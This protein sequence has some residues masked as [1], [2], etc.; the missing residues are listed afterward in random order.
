MATTFEEELYVDK[1]G[2]PHWDGENMA[3]LREYKKRV[4]IEFNT[5]S[6]TTDAGKEKRANLGL[7]LTRGLSGKAWKMVEPLLEDM[8]PLTQTG[9]HELI[10]L[11]LEK[12]DKVAIVRKQQKFDDF[13]K[14][15]RRKRGMEIKEYVQ[16]FHRRYEELK[17]L[18]KGTR[19]SDDLYAY[20][21]L[22]GALLTDDQ[23]R[24]IIMCANNQYE[25]V[26]FEKTLETNYHDLHL[27]EQR[28]SRFEK[29]QAPGAGKSAGKSGKKG[30][31]KKGGRGPGKAY[32]TDYDPDGAHE[33]YEYEEDEEECDVCDPDDAYEVDEG[34]DDIASDAGASEDP[35]INNAYA[36]YDQARAKVKEMQKRRG[37]FKAEGTLTFEERKAAIDKRKQN[38]DCG[39]CG[40]V[41]HWAGDPECPKASTYPRKGR[42]GPKAPPVT[43]STAMARGAATR[44]SSGAASSAGS[45]KKR[46]DA[47]LFVLDDGEDDFYDEDAF[48]SSM[49]GNQDTDDGQSS[50]VSSFRLVGKPEKDPAS[51]TPENDKEFDPDRPA[52]PCPDCDS[53]MVAR[54]NRANKGWFFGCGRFPDCKA[55]RTY[56][57]GRELKAEASRKAEARR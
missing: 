9:G 4:L 21:L 36:A 50:G 52:V 51:S 1:E 24:L 18:D 39:A 23:K 57:N 48:F 31:G 37:F 27:S 35:E 45:H 14:R 42:I 25:T 41:G 44:P 30:G 47:T 40:Q 13:F 20:F 5:Q 12:L 33:S 38:S 11:A 32:F 3:L 17:E 54:Q 28:T 8:V 56:D 46:K 49:A 19:L 34:V 29:A 6:A 7:R 26:L 15:S 2:I 55:T 10:I 43:R 16:Q 53:A 22:E